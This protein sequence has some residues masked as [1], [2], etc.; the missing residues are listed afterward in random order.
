MTKRRKPRAKPT[1]NRKGL[2][3][4]EYRRRSAVHVERLAQAGEHPIYGDEDLMVT[5]TYNVYTRRL[6]NDWTHVVELKEDVFRLPDK[7]FR[8][9][10]RHRKSI[11]TEAARVRGMERRASQLRAQAEADQEAAEAE[12]ARDLGGL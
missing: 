3:P 4:G 9:I 12:R 5:D 1:P 11:V 10:E 2:M 6:D 7:V 8:Q